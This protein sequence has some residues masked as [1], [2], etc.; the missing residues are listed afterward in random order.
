MFGEDDF[1]WQFAVSNRPNPANAKEK[2][3][4]R[5]QSEVTPV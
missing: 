1:G 2:K 3:S 4:E 5:C